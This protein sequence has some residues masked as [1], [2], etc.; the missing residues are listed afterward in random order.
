MHYIK[1]NAEDKLLTYLNN[2]RALFIIGARQVGKTSILKRLAQIVGEDRSIILDLENPEHLMGF[3][4]DINSS[5]QYLKMLCPKTEGRIWI[6]IDEIQ[7]VDDLSR[8]VKY[9]V[10]H[11]TERYKLV[12]TGSS[13][14]L[15]KSSFSESLVGRKDVLELYP[16]SFS[17]F[18]R[19]QGEEPL[20][21]L[22]QQN[23]P[24]MYYQLGI[25]GAKLQRMIQEYI[26]YGSYPRI[27]LTTS[28]EEKIELLRDVVNSYVLRDVKQLF[29][30]EK[31][32]QFNL[33]IRY[34][35]VNLGRELNIMAIS[36]IIGLHWETVQKHIMVMRE[37]YVVSVVK[38]FHANL[39]T[40]IRKMPKVYFVDTGIRNAI[41]NNFNPL[42][43]HTDR[44][45]LFENF[46]YQQLYYQKSYL[47]EIH[48]WKTRNGQEVDFVVN[49]E[50]DLTAYEVKFGGGKSN[51][52]AA[53]SKAYPQA[54]C[55]FV[56][57]EL[58]E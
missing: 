39:N 30:I 10:D 41:I 7:Y 19:F 58:S 35:S 22:I 28:R 26:V 34:L 2:K 38:P 20:A 53:F 14:L 57:Y 52:F 4:R 32:D 25:P 43:L 11:Y 55:K 29:K 24:D 1:R 27:S 9:I 31:L 46:I 44:G 49:D 45:E 6:F 50:G 54:K 37:A 36:K 51:H 33:L 16:L 13:S 47:S 15:I 40:E 3:G 56:R 18:C 21:D 5:L 8:T 23:P 42:E 17:E 48:F 12:M